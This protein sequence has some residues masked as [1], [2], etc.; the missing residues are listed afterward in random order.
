[1]KWETTSASHPQ[2]PA[3]AL[4]LSLSLKLLSASGP[5]V[6]V[7]EAAPIFWVFSAWQFDFS[8][9]RCQGP[10]PIPVLRGPTL[11]PCLPNQASHAPTQRETRPGSVSPVLGAEAHS[12]VRFINGVAPGW[13]ESPCK[14]QQGAICVSQSTMQLDYIRD[15]WL[16][17]RRRFKHR[18]TNTLIG[19]RLIWQSTEEVS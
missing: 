14:D 16:K 10:A 15:E 6:L 12:C 7:T 1:M 19:A 2:W 17:V 13:T 4:C 5:I 11:P 3:H 8:L 18:V 9:L